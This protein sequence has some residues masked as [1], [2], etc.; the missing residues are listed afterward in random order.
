MRDLC[1]VA[2]ILQFCYQPW[3]PTRW[4][5]IFPAAAKTI[6]ILYVLTANVAHDGGSAI[7]GVTV[8]QLAECPESRPLDQI[9]PF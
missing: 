1:F 6:T 5:I 9:D 4:D 3:L 2:A 7:H 8:V